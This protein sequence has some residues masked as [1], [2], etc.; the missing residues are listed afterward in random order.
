MPQNQNEIPLELNNEMRIAFATGNNA[1]LLCSF[2]RNLPLLGKSGQVKGSSE[3]IKVVYP[4]CRAEY[5][6]V[7]NGGD[8]KEPQKWY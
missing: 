6:V 4:N 3:N 8:Y 2:T 1:S 7:P 5:F